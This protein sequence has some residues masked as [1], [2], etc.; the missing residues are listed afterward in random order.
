MGQASK[1]MWTLHPAAQQIPLSILE[2]P[3]PEPGAGIPAS[4]VWA[5]VGIIHRKLQPGVMR[6]P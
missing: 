2:V 6:A 5:A 1:I 4:A 3:G